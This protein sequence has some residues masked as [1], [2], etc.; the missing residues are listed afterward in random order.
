MGGKQKLEEEHRHRWSWLCVVD[1]FCHL[2]LLG[3][4]RG[5]FFLLFFFLLGTLSYLRVKELMAGDTM[6]GDMTM[7]WVFFFLRRGM[8]TFFC[9]GF[10][11]Q[12]NS[13]DLFPRLDLFLRCWFVLFLSFH[14]VQQTRLKSVLWV[15]RFV[16]FRNVLKRSFYQWTKQYK[17]DPYGEKM[18]AGQE[19][20][21]PKTH[22]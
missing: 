10:S 15:F 7:G 17:D 11:L 21:V 6:A 2:A 19:Q 4:S 16:F 5:K 8:L 1:R 20:Y 18:F 9:F 14:F 3:R 22:H 13:G 12:W